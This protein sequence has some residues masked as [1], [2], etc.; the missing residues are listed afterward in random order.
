MQIDPVLVSVNWWDNC[1][2]N[3]ML[4]KFAAG[5]ASEFYLLLQEGQFTFCDRF[6]I[7]LYTTQLVQM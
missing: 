5:N 2:E 4:K 7:Y 6:D 1:F 3:G